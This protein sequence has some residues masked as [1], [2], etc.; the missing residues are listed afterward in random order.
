MLGPTVPG[1]WF[2]NLSKLPYTQYLTFVDLLFS[3]QIPV[4]SNRWS[5]LAGDREIMTLMVK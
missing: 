3:L 5:E 1:V 4:P 2:C